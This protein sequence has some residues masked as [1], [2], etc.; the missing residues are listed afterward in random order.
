MRS[1][2]LTVGSAFF[3]L[4]AQVS[5]VTIGPLGVVVR[6]ISVITISIVA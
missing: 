6:S 2:L 4:S 1:Y 3:I 5:T